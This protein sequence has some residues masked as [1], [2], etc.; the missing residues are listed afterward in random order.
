MADLEHKGGNLEN[1]L[2]RHV[3]QILLNA[4]YV[5]RPCHRTGRHRLDSARRG[6]H[7]GTELG[8]IVKLLGFQLIDTMVMALVAGD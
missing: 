4:D 5:W 2:V 8:P 6:R 3:R 7:L 1:E